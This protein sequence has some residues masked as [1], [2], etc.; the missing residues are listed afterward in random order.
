MQDRFGREWTIKTVEHDPVRYGTRRFYKVSAE[1][2]NIPQ[3]L[4][5]SFFA[6]FESAEHAEAIGEKIADLIPYT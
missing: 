1:T 6:A 2:L 5:L 4:E 3:S